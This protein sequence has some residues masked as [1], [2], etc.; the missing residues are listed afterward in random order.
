MRWLTLPV[1]LCCLT[2]VALA[3]TAPDPSAPVPPAP[4]APAPDAPAP[5]V[6]EPPP[7]VAPAPVVEPAPAP[8]AVAPSPAPP[9]DKKSPMTIIVDGY[10]QPQFRLRQNSSVTDDTDGFRFARVRPMLRAS[11][12]LQDL[13]LTATFEFEVTPTFAMQDAY[14][15]VTRKLATDGKT[16]GKLVFDVGQMRTPLSRQQMLSDSR[17][18]FVDKAQIATIAPRRDLGARLTLV[19]PYVPRLKVIAGVFNGEGPNQ[20][21]NI[22]EKKLY[23][24]RLE[25][26]L[27]GK[28]ASLAEG[29][30]GSDY[31]TIAG[32]YGHNGINSG[33]VSEKVQYLGVDLAGAY[34]GLS[35]EIEYLDV[36]HTVEPGTSYHANGW[37]AQLA[38]LLPVVLPRDTRLEVGARVEEIDRN[39]TT[40]IVAA[41][42]ANQSQ[43]IYTGMITYYLRKHSLKLALALQHFDEIE[44]KNGVGEDASYKNDQAVLQ[45]TYRME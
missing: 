25:A 6:V 28:E 41:G 32:S 24:T 7:V 39:D 14:A 15:G 13:E 23:A 2:S 34:R 38:Y 18:T 19:V 35:G 10:M 40:A 20:V 11:T 1:S 21:Q 33:D 31:L 3:Q 9:D 8:I 29:A 12:K 42:D 43:R 27:L 30:F 16:D 26:T 44:D 17:L 22:D 37:N 4:V 36:K 45:L 5:V